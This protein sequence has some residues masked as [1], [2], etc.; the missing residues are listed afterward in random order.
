VLPLSLSTDYQVT[1]GFRGVRHD[2]SA[3]L[4][5]PFKRGFALKGEASFSH[6]TEEGAT[7]SPFLFG[8]HGVYEY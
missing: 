4:D 8:L 7:V 3:N 5:V 2:L 6:F 1:H